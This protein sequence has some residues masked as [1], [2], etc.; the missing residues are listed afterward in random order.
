MQQQDWQWKEEQKRVFLNNIKANYD[1]EF[2]Q[3]KEKLII[4]LK[5][6]DKGTIRNINNYRMK[7]WCDVLSNT[8]LNYQANNARPT[9]VADSALI[10]FDKRFNQ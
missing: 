10:E 6:K 2:E 9:E 7:L 4:D 5:T 8:I 3:I 1:R